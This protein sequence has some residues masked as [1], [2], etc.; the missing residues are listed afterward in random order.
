MERH[1]LYITGYNID[2]GGGS[3]EHVREICFHLAKIGW[4]VTLVGR[5]INSSNI[6]KRNS[7]NLEIIRVPSSRD[8][9]VAAF[10]LW[11][12]VQQLLEKQRFDLAYVRHSRKTL[13]ATNWLKWKRT[14]YIVEINTNVFGEYRATGKNLFT[15]I[16]ADVLERIQIY[17][18]SGA[19]CVTRELV[20]YT[21]KRIP[22]DIPIWIT[23]NGFR[24]EETSLAI[25]D[26]GLRRTLGISEEEVVLIFIGHLSIWHG[27]DI[28]LTV[29][30]QR[31]ST[32]LWVVGEGPEENNL[33]QLASKLGVESRIHWWGY[34][35]GE[36]LQRLLCGSDIGIGSLALHRNGLHEAQPLKVRQYL[37]AGIPTI[38]GYKDTLLGNNSIGV[39]F[40]KTVREIIFQIDQIQ[41]QG[42]MRNTEYRQKIR[43][44]A[45]QHLSWTAIAHQTSDILL[46]WLDSNNQRTDF[47]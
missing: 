21:R 43:D 24:M 14:P 34:Q 36:N 2:A 23:G 9:L 47:H 7:H 27:I 12:T 45:L 5:A 42:L 19:F 35:D 28:I 10:A 37:G 17:H 3:G 25:F 8:G 38:V 16:V 40:A 44:F 41:Q 29:L 32:R 18:A 46:S 30:Q 33:K 4:K 26:Q 1:L 39:F 13:F 31:P 6:V 20:D 22:T 11:Y 15:S